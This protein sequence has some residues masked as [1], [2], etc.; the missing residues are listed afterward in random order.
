MGCDFHSL[1][2]LFQRVR[3]ALRVRLNEFQRNGNSSLK[4]IDIWNYL[5]IEKWKKGNGLMLS[6][7]VH[8]I[9]NVE[10][11]DIE[12]YLKKVKENQQ[13]THNFEELL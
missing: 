2:E 6:D 7:I 8:D 4:E 5:M 12:L 1:N 10:Y 3:P 13:E 11:L 9:M